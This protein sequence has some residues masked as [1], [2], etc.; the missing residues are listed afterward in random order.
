MIGSTRFD[1]K[2]NKP[3]TQ[4]QLCIQKLLHESYTVTF[5]DNLI[6]HRI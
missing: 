6:F 1:K 3:I 2:R 4:M 5:T